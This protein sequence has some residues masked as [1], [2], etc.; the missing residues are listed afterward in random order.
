M[1]QNA[2][3]LENPKPYITICLFLTVNG[4]KLAWS[5]TLATSTAGE[6]ASCHNRRWL[7]ISTRHLLSDREQSGWV[8]AAPCRYFILKL[9]V[10]SLARSHRPR[11]VAIM[12]RDKITTY[13]AVFFLLLSFSLSVWIY[14]NG[15]D[16]DEFWS[17]GRNEAAHENE[18]KTAKA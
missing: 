11:E 4:F 3:T 13:L 14:R 18:I 5:R 1:E 9:F 6:A 8:S 15:Y 2:M 17:R 16:L 7:P 12:K 10:L